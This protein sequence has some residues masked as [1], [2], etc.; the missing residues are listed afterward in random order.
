MGQFS[1]DPSA[2]PIE[3][4]GTRGAVLLL[5]G[6]TGSP[7]TFGPMAQG[8]SEQGFEVSVPLLPGHGTS[9][10]S[11]QHTRWNDWLMAAR[12]RFD[13]LASRH[14]QVFIVGF[15]MGSLL[16]TVLAQER[17]KQVAGLVAMAV[18][19]DLGI[20]AQTVLRLARVLPIANFLPFVEK[21]NGPDVSD[22]AVAAAMPS[23]D[24]TP[25]SAAASMVKGQTLAMD[26]A[27]RLSIP[28]LVMHGRHDHV[29][30]LRNA[31]MFLE[32]LKTPKQ[33]LIIYPKSWHILPLDLEHE[34]VQKDVLDFLES[35]ETMGRPTEESS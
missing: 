7:Y 18:P 28:V 21:K 23:Y 10:E 2:Q 25:I 5:H 32:L 17:G 30:P 16:G 33:R 14:K 27:A 9:P 3:I 1:I 26:R 4:S 15:S 11:L 22:A 31:R 29:A 6:L 13:D 34:Q 20:K 24:R 12:S 8:I 19:L 35:P